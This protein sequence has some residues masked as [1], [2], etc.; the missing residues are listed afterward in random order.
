MTWKTITQLITGE[1]VNSRPPTRRYDEGKRKNRGKDRV[2]AHEG[3]GANLSIYNPSN[4]C[5][6]H[7]KGDGE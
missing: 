3:C 1:P 4:R 6:L 2:C 5:A 7:S